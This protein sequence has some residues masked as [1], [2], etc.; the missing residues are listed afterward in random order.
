MKKPPAAQPLDPIGAPFQAKV[1][2]GCKANFNN[3]GWII[4]DCLEKEDHELFWYGFLPRVKGWL[5]CDLMTNPTETA[6]LSH[7]DDLLCRKSGE[8]SNDEVEE[9]EL[10]PDEWNDCNFN[11]QAIYNKY[12]V[13]PE[14]D[15]KIPVFVDPANP[16]RYILITA[17][18]CQEWAMAIVSGLFFVYHCV[19]FL[20]AP[21]FAVGCLKE[22][23]RHIS[24]SQI[25]PLQVSPFFFQE[26]KNLSLLSGLGTSSSLAQMFADVIADFQLVLLQFTLDMVHLDYSKI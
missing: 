4:Q 14:Y 23:C 12:P 18:A 2:A 25:S 9:A 22:W 5:K 20:T 11:M 16:N 1:I 19:S 26:E 21:K 10:D 15:R 3:T 7:Q 8:E 13:Q 6:K 24:P 17:A